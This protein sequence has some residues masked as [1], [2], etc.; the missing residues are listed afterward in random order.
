MEAIPRIAREAAGRSGRDPATIESYLRETMRYHLG[1]E[2]VEA[3][4]LY[5]RHAI[6]IGALP[7]GCRVRQ[8]DEG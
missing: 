3:M 8:L 1:P 2:E 4:G 5:Y 6:E 7:E